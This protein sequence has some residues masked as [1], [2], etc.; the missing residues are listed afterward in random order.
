MV[1]RTLPAARLAVDPA[2]QAFRSQLRAGQEQVDAQAEVAAEGTGP[3]V[4]PG[5]AAAGLLEAPE[6]V[7]QAEVQQRLQGLPLGR[8]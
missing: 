5:V 2:L 8:R 6:Q 4:P 1:A 7:G 3:V